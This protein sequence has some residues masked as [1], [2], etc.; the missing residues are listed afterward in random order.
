M[1]QLV[2]IWQLLVRQPALFYGYRAQF[3]PQMVNSLNRL[4]LPPNS[5]LEN[6]TL[7]V[8]LVDLIIAWDRIRV[9]RVDEK[10]TDEVQEEK[11]KWKTI[12]WK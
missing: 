4:A 10:K 9:Q 11:R 8:A 6:R 12:Q 7:A 2:H 1:Q 5:P 3:V